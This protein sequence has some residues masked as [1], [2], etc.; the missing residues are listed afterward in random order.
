[1]RV[2]II[3]IVLILIVVAIAGVIHFINKKYRDFLKVNSLSLQYLKEIN[4]RY[5]FYK[6]NNYSFSHTYDNENFYISISCKDYLIYELQFIKSNVS[7]D[8]SLIKQ[9]LYRYSLYKDEVKMIERFGD[10]KASQGKLKMKKLLTFEKRIFNEE[11]VKPQLKYS[12]LVE[13]KCARMNGQIYRTKYYEFNSNE[14]TEYIEAL[15]EKK[16]DF[17]L[18]RSVW[19]SICRVERG[20]VSN[21]MRFAIYKRDGYRCKICGRGGRYYK[22]LE[23]DH[24]KPIAKGGKTTYNNLQTLCKNCNK[25]KGDKY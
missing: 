16:G 8:I 9:N 7:H 19:D 4:N 5:R 13:L 10:Y 12:I 24:I 2:E 22:D 25:L 1:M 14:I 21:K 11:I 20:K 18:N 23:I 17:Y 6:T 15:K 3:I